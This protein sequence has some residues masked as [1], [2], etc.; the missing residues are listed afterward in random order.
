MRSLGPTRRSA[1][2]HVHQKAQEQSVKHGLRSLL[3][4]WGTAR[5]GAADLVILHGWSCRPR[6]LALATQTDR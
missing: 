3:A 5:A 6:T 4:G 2:Y 1:P